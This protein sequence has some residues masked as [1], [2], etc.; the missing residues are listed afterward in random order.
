M[1]SKPASSRTPDQIIRAFRTSSN[2]TYWARTLQ[3]R[4]LLRSMISLM[5]AT[6]NITT[7]TLPT[8]TGEQRMTHPEAAND[9]I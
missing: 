9:H 8:T 5:T 6:D 7:I 2:M 1:V 3:R 4:R